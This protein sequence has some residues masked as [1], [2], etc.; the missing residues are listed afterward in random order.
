ML[1]NFGS[2]S[3]LENDMFDV[4]KDMKNNVQTLATTAHHIYTLRTYYTKLTEETF[5]LARQ[6][7]YPKANQQ[8]FLRFAAL[9]IAR[10]YVCL[11]VLE[12]AARKSNGIFSP[13]TYQRSDLICD[14]EKTTNRLKLLHY[15][16]KTSI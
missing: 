11:D 9:I 1:Y 15:Y 16:A 3:Q 8:K 12:Q 13:T 4:Y 7:N 6:T 5:A 2:I 10:G 14:M